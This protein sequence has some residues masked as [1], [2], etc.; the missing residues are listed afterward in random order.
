MWVLPSVVP[1]NWEP[2]VLEPEGLH[3]PAKQGPPRPQVSQPPLAVPALA[4]AFCPGVRSSD[5]LL[6]CKALPLHPKW[7]RTGDL[8]RCVEDVHGRPRSRHSREKRSDGHR[9]SEPSGFVAGLGGSLLLKYWGETE[10]LAGQPG[11]RW[12]APLGR[13]ARVQVPSG[14]PLC[15]ALLLPITVTGLP[16]DLLV[17][18]AQC[19]LRA[20]HGLATVWCHP[21]SCRWPLLQLANDL[22]HSVEIN[23]LN[24][25]RS[26]PCAG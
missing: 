22:S 6:S 24:S 3:L 18:T 12:A 14:H 17:L 7:Y 1:G 8:L 5:S 26:V 16:G 19:L 2:T 4:A 25:R 10:Q 20:L 9:P 15:S 21:W 11:P 13:P 23:Q